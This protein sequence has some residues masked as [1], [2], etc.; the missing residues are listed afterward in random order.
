[1]SHEKLPKQVVKSRSQEF[2][3]Q[4]LEANA[5][6]RDDFSILDA[7]FDIEELPLEQYVEK[8]KEHGHLERISVEH[9]EIGLLGVDTGWLQGQYEAMEYLEELGHREGLLAKGLRMIY[10]RN[11]YINEYEEIGGE[12]THS[13]EI[14]GEFLLV[15]GE[16]D[17]EHL[18]FS[19][20]GTIELQVDRHEVVTRIH[21]ENVQMHC[22][23][24]A[25][26]A[27]FDDE[28]RREEGPPEKSVSYV[29]G[30]IENILL[31]GAE[32][33]EQEVQTW[34]QEF[35]LFF[36]PGLTPPADYNE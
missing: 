8:V 9:G 33:S 26:W 24:K 18:V 27:D 28:L 29:L 2:I 1:M 34:L 16:D 19:A 23:T 3:T 14:D 25:L 22:G 17:S 32:V 10:I 21:R 11:N 13:I 30:A 5:R 15:S 7:L 36:A 35:S 12:G 31:E 6:L 4:S 20:Q